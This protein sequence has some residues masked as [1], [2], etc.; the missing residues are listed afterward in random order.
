MSARAA[1]SLPAC[2]P[3]VPLAHPP[4]HR[5]CPHRRW[6]PLSSRAGRRRRWGPCAGAACRCA[7]WARLRADS[8][9]KL[10]G[11]GLCCC[12][13]ICTP[14]GSITL[15]PLPRVQAGV[16]R[17]QAAA[18]H[19]TGGANCKPA[20]PCRRLGIA[21]FEGGALSEPVQQPMQRQQPAAG[22]E[23][24]RAVPAPSCPT[25]PVP[26]PPP[27]PQ[28]FKEKLHLT[29]GLQR[30]ASINLA[31]LDKVTGGFEARAASAAREKAA[32]PAP[33][34]LASAAAGAG[35]AAGPMGAR[36][37]GD[38]SQEAGGGGGGGGPNPVRPAL[39]L[40]ANPALGWVIVAAAP[41]AVH[42]QH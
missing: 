15:P 8:S 40:A 12:A 14:S 29:A 21:P 22:S 41:A 16:R 34:D 10:A 42:T 25:A 27:S 30:A 36:Q 9:R 18:G 24:Q 1:L 19:V 32:G 4:T 35:K 28:E 23:R 11:W 3:A 26:P 2:L 17:A 37:R 33:D 20:A 31:E 5:A 39:Q 6:V 7:W 13:A 38:S